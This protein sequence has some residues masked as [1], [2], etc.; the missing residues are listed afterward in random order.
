M[1]TTTAF[2]N[3]LAAQFSVEAGKTYD[4]KMPNWDR[5]TRVTIENGKGDFAGELFVRFSPDRY[6]SKLRDIPVAATFTEVS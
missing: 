1:N 6:P 5:P 2:N 4:Y 3:K